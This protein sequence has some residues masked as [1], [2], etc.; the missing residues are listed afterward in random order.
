MGADE[1]GA[2]C[3]ID[4]I[5]RKWNLENLDDRLL[6]R[7]NAGASLRELETYYNQ[8]ILD[9]AMRDSGVEMLDGEVENLYH[10][11][12]DAETSAGTKVDV[13]SRLERNGLDPDTI[14]SDFVSYQTVR[15]HLRD[16]L[17]IETHRNTEFD[18]TDAKNTVFKLLSR[19]EAITE[20]TIDRLRSAGHLSISEPEVTLSLRIACTKCG[21]EYQFTR[22]LD[23]GNCSCEKTNEPSNE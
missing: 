17:G 20:R 4:R 14:L 5:S 10:L 19:T 9:A 21:E 7:R 2:D 13:Q 22:L 18:I 15:T 11:L 3:K 16:C 8:Q 12:T 23:R 6:E 1:T